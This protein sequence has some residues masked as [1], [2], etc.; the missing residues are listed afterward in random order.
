MAEISHHPAVPRSAGRSVHVVSQ[1]P[2]DE[3]SGGR[4]PWSQSPY[5]A[6]RWWAQDGR[7]DGRGQEDGRGGGRGDVRSA[8]RTA[9]S[10]R[11]GRTGIPLHEDVTSAPI[12]PDGVWRTWALEAELMLNIVPCPLIALPH[13]MAYVAWIPTEF[14]LQSHWPNPR[15]YPSVEKVLE[16]GKTAYNHAYATLIRHDLVR[17]WAANLI[18]GPIPAF[19]YCLTDGKFIYTLVLLQ[20]FVFLNPLTPDFM[21]I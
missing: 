5:A 2:W 9:A 17:P 19:V 20:K 14:E 12:Y 3:Q 18:Q 8:G 11:G 15:F 21:S 13:W 6:D 16:I 7:S 10:Q 4:R 1:R